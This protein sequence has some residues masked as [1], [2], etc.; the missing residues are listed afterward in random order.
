MAQVPSLCQ[1]ECYTYMHCTLVG[2]WSFTSLQHL[3]SYQEGYRLVTMHTLYIQVYITHT[4][5]Y[6]LY[7]TQCECYGYIYYTLV[8]CWSFVPMQHLRSYQDVYRHVTVRAHGN[9]K[10][11]GPLGNQAARS[12]HLISH[13]VTLSWHLG[14]PALS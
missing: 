3:R 13:S 10:S 2:C 5:C 7:S 11:A 14:Q 4:E 12:W 1:S 9:F 6:I 8:G